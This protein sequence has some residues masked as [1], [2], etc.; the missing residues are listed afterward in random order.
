ML[1]PTVSQLVYLEKNTHVGLKTRY[2]LLYDSCRLV[3]VG[4][5]V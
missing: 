1:R 2:L 4:R 3:D 5:S